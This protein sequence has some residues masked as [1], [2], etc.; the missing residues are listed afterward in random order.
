MRVADTLRIKVPP[1]IIF[2]AVKRFEVEMDGGDYRGV[3]KKA[4]LTFKE[5]A[6]G[7][8]ANVH[9]AGSHC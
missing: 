8:A 5:V 4:S 1:S 2:G 3:E 9:H 7:M 6:F